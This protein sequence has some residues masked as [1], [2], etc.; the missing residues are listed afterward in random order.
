MP[1]WDGILL[2]LAKL[3]NMEGGMDKH[4]LRELETVVMCPYLLNDGERA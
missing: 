1:L 4:S 3:G 2:V